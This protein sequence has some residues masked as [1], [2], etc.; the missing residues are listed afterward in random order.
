M[1]PWTTSLSWK[2]MRTTREPSTR[3]SSGAWRTTGDELAQWALDVDAGMKGEVGYRT[4]EDAALA[5]WE[6]HPEAAARVISVDYR[7][8]NNAVVVTDTV[9]SHP[10]WN[11]CL[12]TP[13]GWV[14]TH[15][16]N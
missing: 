6:D 16:H 9:P 13:N 1:V 12:R 11:Y 4:P 2:T 3:R 15:D 10:I 5:E 7:D 14:L 8:D